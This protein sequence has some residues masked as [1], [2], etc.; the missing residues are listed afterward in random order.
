MLCSFVLICV[1]L[2][3]LLCENVINQK[4]N[5]Y[6]KKSRNHIIETPTEKTTHNLS[7]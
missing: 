3:P 2:S 5:D 4:L 1:H 7:Y 6:L